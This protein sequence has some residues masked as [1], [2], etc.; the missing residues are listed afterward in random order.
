MYKLCLHIDMG[1]P[2]GFWDKANRK[3]EASIEKNSIELARRKT[4]KIKMKEI[5]KEIAEGV[6]FDISGSDLYDA[7]LEAAG[8]LKYSIVSSDKAG[9]IV[10]FQTPRV[11]TFWDGKLSCFVL[12][13]GPNAKVTVSGS[14]NKGSTTAALSPGQGG[15]VKNFLS[16][17][18]STGSFVSEMGKFKKEI[19]RQVQ[20]YPKSAVSNAQSGSLANSLPDQLNQLK[21]L[22][23]SGA[24][25]KEEFEKAKTRLLG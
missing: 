4:E 6:Y 5:K 16:E 10:T 1:K 20:I 14:P 19:W 12:E 21:Q 15:G 3:L 18:A 13:I 22:F 8:V 11:E 25:T 23:E 7:T 17:Q 2:G 24:L 9:Y